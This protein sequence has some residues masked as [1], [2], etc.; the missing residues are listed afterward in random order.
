MSE[1]RQQAAKSIVTCTLEVDPALKHILDPAHPFHA[2]ISRALVDGLTNLMKT[3]GIPGQ[4]SV[5]LHVLEDAVPHFMNV[6]INGQPCPYQIYIY[7]RI[8]SYVKAS[9]TDLQ[10]DYEVIWAWLRGLAQPLSE[11]TGDEAIDRHPLIVFLTCACLEIVK[12]QPAVL[13]G[14]EQ[15]EAIKQ[16]LPPPAAL[17]EEQTEKAEKD[18]WLQAE[19]LHRVLTKVLQ[20][21]ISLAD[22]YT[23]GLT[24]F[25]M[26]ESSQEEI[27][28]ELIAKLSADVLEI[29]LPQDLLRTFTIAYARYLHGQLRNVRQTMMQ[30]FG[31]SLPE[32]RFVLDEDLKPGSFACKINSLLMLPWVVV[33]EDALDWME[34]LLLQ[35]VRENRRCFVHRRVVD[36]LLAPYKQSSPLLFRLSSRRLSIYRLT[37]AL[38]ILVIEELPI[39]DLAFI[40]ER[41]LNY[42]YIVANPALP[43]T[44]EE[45]FPVAFQEGQPQL[46]HPIYQASFVRIGLKRAISYKYAGEQRQL[47]SYVFQVEPL[48]ELALS[49]FHDYHSQ[50]QPHPPDTQPVVITSIGGRLAVQD[51]IN[52]GSLPSIPV[53]AYQELIPGLHVQ[54]VERVVTDSPAQPANPSES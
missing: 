43:L 2:E 42:R 54:L 19:W 25:S 12:L 53:L 40:L 11:S 38:R 9:L 6:Q 51:F 30:T 50:E 49:V 5:E 34:P 36:Q 23:I 7:R 10:E 17:P 21:N 14:L 18:E 4:P 24:L 28:E 13:L 33:A 20:Q 44:F 37:Q 1:D 15:V 41:L 46:D 27:A 32:M 45:L 16:L 47:Y 35:N 48:V 26:R 39:R 31:L 22:T 29:H 8:Y 52:A 3:L